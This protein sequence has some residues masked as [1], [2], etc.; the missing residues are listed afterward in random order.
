MLLLLC[1]VMSSERSLTFRPAHA[2]FYHIKWPPLPGVTSTGSYKRQGQGVGKRC[3]CLCVCAY[4]YVSVVC[5]SACM[6][7]PSLFSRELSA[8]SSSMQA[9][10]APV[11]QPW[12]DITAESLLA[13]LQKKKWMSAKRSLHNTKD[14][15]CSYLDPSC[16]WLWQ[17]SS[18]SARLCDPDPKP[19]T[20]TGQEGEKGAEGSAKDSIEVFSHSSE[21]LCHCGPHWRRETNANSSTC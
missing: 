12:N 2:L 6:G 13:W 9:K 1:W 3:V 8:I 20:N 18:P 5:V 7:V 16:R 14:E 15:C 17:T 19:G 4:A 11:R 21:S 10:K